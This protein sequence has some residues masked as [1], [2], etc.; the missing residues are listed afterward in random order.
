MCQTYADESSTC[1]GGSVVLIALYFCIAVAALC[2]AA[3]LFKTYS[4][5]E[6]ETQV[7]TKIVRVE[8]P[9]ESRAE[10]TRAVAAV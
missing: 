2:Q 7:G 4:V 1:V 6:A 5:P 10:R 9:E 3:S 8:S